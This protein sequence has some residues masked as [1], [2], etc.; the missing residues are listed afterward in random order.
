MSIAIFFLLLS[1]NCLPL[2]GQF[3][4]AAVALAGEDMGMSANQFSIDAGNDLG[5][6]EVASIGMDF[7]EH[8]NDVEQIAEFFAGVFRV[9]VVNRQNKFLALGKK[10]FAD[11]LRRLSPIPGTTLVT[12]QGADGVKQTVKM[13]AYRFHVLVSIG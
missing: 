11:G 9:G 7:G 2:L 6:D 1:L 12:A 4:L 10:V 5:K 8:D 13:L 3:G